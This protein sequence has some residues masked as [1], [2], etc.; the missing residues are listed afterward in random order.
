MILILLSCLSL[1][2]NS[3]ASANTPEDFNQ[4]IVK[5]G[6]E[7]EDFD[8]VTD[9]G[10]IL[11]LFR[12]TG[13]ESKQPVLL[14]H[15]VLDS[16]DTFVIRGNDSVALNLAEAGYDV[17]I[18]N[19]RGNKYSRRHVKLSPDLDKAF[20]DYSLHEM[21]IY[22]LPATIDFILEKTGKAKLSAIGHSEGNTIFYV[23]GSLMPEYNEKVSVMIAL[24]PIAYFHHAKPF[25]S[26]LIAVWPV[27][28]GFYKITFTEEVLPDRSAS[29]EL[30]R[31][32]C[33]RGL[34]GYEACVIGIGAVVGC[35]KDEIEPDFLK[36]AVEYFPAGTSR[37]NLNHLVQITRSS[38]FAQYDYGLI[39]NRILYKS[40][41]PP[42]YDLANVTMPVALLV[43]Q[44]DNFAV[45]EDAERLRDVLPNVADYHVMERKTFSHIDFVWGKH[46][47]EYL[48]PILDDLLS[49]FS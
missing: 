35:D 14:V 6:R 47:P 41:S 24:G 38:G 44:N 36:R 1:I 42:E 20:W 10:Y 13:N 19:C 16:A 28:N 25:A 23:L 5:Y 48:M 39:K 40:I 9:D 22:D 27:V 30:A 49:K 45:E 34:L 21:G 4:L 3:A 8:V 33:N 7:S 37:K 15:G 2:S 29:A 17:W 11:K 32:V 12:I 18:A 26:D 43:G 31:F 46:I